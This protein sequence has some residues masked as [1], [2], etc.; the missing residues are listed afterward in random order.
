MLKNATIGLCNYSFAPLGW[1]LLHGAIYCWLYPGGNSSTSFFVFF[2]VIFLLSVVRY[3]AKNWY[4]TCNFRDFRI[5]NLPRVGLIPWNFAFD[6]T[7][8]L[9]LG[10]TENLCFN[11]L[12]KLKMSLVAFFWCLT[13][14]RLCLLRRCTLKH[15]VSWLESRSG[16]G[17]FVVEVL[18]DDA[19]WVDKLRFCCFCLS[20][21]LRILHLRPLKLFYLSVS[22]V[23][24]FAKWRC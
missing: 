23:P 10:S 14:K 17:C 24:G 16:G 3:N 7:N 2:L 5:W 11:A 20:D 9:F 22:L 19:I 1:F 18:L 13:T 15:Q 8:A 4:F 21:M 12:Q 6:A